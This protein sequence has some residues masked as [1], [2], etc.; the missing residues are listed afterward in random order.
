MNYLLNEPAPPIP[1]ELS[2]Y[3]IVVNE[4]MIQ[5]NIM[6]HVR[7][8]LI[9]SQKTGRYRIYCNG[10]S[11]ACSNMF[12]KEHDSTLTPPIEMR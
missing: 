4:K 12:G 10:K 11:Y 3:Y 7:G 6:E 1:Y 2:Y 5:H 8:T 9:R